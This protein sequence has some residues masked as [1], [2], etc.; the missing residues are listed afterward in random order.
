M[1]S[2]DILHTKLGREINVKCNAEGCTFAYKKP[3]NDVLYFEFNEVLLA[4]LIKH[5]PVAHRCLAHEVLGD[6][7][8]DCILPIGH[9]D[10]ANREYVGVHQG[11]VGTDDNQLHISWYF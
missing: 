4:H 11:V 2:I 10:R 8:V 7:R 9:T 1:I 5:S 6:A 3:I